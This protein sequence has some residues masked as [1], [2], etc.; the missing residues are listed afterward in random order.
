[1]KVGVVFFHSNI[2]KI[3]K[4][5]WI[6]RC[7]DSIKQQ[8]HK[9]LHLYEVNYGDDKKQFVEGAKFFNKK[10]E[11]HSVAMNFIISKAFDDGCDYVF[12]TNMDDFYEFIRIGAQLKFFEQG[13]DLISSDFFEVDENDKI[14]SYRHM[15][16]FGS[17]RANL[18]VGH[19]IVPHPAVAYSKDF[20]ADKENR[21]GK[22]DIPEED[23]I[24]WK[25]AIYNGYKFKVINEPLFFYRRHENQICK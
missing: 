10:F 18:T 2:L 6:D 13:Y 8:T 17:L 9:P 24:L 21:Y 23:L 14:L 19:N 15:N 5:K 12:N 7:I 3:Y 1:M 20:W 25:K 22:D 4:Q 11:N 16:G